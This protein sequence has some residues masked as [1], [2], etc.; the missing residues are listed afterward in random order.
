MPSKLDQHVATIEDWLAVE[1]Q[2]TA[3][4]IVCRLSQFSTPNDTPTMDYYQEKRF[5]IAA[6]AGWLGPSVLSLMARAR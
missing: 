6:V 5:R 1:P 2:L 4:A 3:L